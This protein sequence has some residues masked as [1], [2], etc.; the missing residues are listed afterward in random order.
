MR[1]VESPRFINSIPFHERRQ[2]EEASPYAPLRLDLGLILALRETHR[3]IRIAMQEPR[4][5]EKATIGE[6]DQ[7]QSDAAVSGRGHANGH[8]DPGDRSMDNNA[9]AGEADNAPAVVGARIVSLEPEAAP[10]LRKGRG[11]CIR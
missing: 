4:L 2:A 6:S 3:K 1:G 10:C 8:G 9:I 7:P 5:V 11:Q